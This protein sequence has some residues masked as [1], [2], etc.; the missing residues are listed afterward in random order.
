MIGLNKEQSCA[1]ILYCNSN[2]SPDAGAVAVVQ[3]A[4]QAVLNP[5]LNASP[6]VNASWIIVS[7]A[8]DTVP[9]NLNLSQVL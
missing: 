7:W 1:S 4:L 3:S 9:F 2:L 8:P 6:E 5:L